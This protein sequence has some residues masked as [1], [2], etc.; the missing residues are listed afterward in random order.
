VIANLLKREYVLRQSA[1][2]IIGIGLLLFF[3][4]YTLLDQVLAG[5]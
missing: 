2:P 4:L 3:F 1:R 5:K